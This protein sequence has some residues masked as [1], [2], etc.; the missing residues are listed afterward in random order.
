MNDPA[1][2]P[3]ILRVQ[4]RAITDPG[5]LLLHTSAREPLV[6]LREGEGL[7][8]V[9]AKVV[10][11]ALPGTD[12]IT[13]VTAEWRRIVESAEID[14]EVGVPGSGLV[15]FGTFA[16]SPDSAAHS[17]L[18]IPS[19]V[20]G[21]RGGVTWL[22][23]INDADAPTPRDLTGAPPLTLEPGQQSPDGYRDAVRRAVERIGTGKVVLAR[24]LVG[25]LWNGADIRSI[26]QRL[27]DAHPESTTYAVDGMIGASPETLVR[28]FDG[29]VRARVL[30]GSAARGAD[31]A[32]DAAASAA[33]VSSSKDLREHGFAR[34]SVLDALAPHSS[35]L[36]AGEPRPLRLPN[37]WHLASDVSG[38]VADGS[39]SLDLVAALHP[40]AA[41]GGT[42]LTEALALI[43]E[44]EPFD[45]GRYAGPVGWIDGDGD[46]EWAIAL[47]GA[48]V[49]VDTETDASGGWTIALSE[50]PGGTPN[51]A[52][53]GT[54]LV[55]AL[56]GAGIVAGSDP[57]AELAE[58]ELKF[59]P[60]L[61]ALSGR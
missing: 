4:T 47:R 61:E 35:R 16:F 43:D 54:T 5:D 1:T 48:Q 56:A 32:S 31:E 50:A 55:R 34:A 10:I 6:F 25:H 23:T 59:R 37:L 29:E 11:R 60:I 19:A 45:R 33:L 21:R 3:R 24:D 57:D 8:G 7:I 44:L 27:I 39:S 46:G 41:V 14:D 30:A 42:P 38:R 13:S 22:T 51:E 26:L 52:P 15:A 49:S 20:L 40:T 58:T 36:N 17:E 9:D 2:R 18:I 53:A 28:V 12:H